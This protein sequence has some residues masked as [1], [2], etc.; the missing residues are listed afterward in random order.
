MVKVVEYLKVLNTQKAVTSY[1]GSGECYLV[2]SKVR[3]Y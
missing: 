2:P 1:K 3:N